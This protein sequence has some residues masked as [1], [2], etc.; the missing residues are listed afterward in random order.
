MIS[1]VAL[2]AFGVRLPS[3]G[4]WRGLHETS[5]NIAVILLGLHIALHWQWIVN[6]VK[7]YVIAP[8]LPRRRTPQLAL[9]AERVTM[10]QAQQEV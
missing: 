4:I 1:E 3:G 9:D 5:A 6:M 2:P 8:L 10:T 7:R